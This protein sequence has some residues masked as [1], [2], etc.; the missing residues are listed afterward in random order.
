VTSQ[1][2][3]MIRSPSLT[4]LSLLVLLVFYVVFGGSGAQAQISF[5]QISD[6][7]VF[8]DT[9]DVADNRWNDKAAFISFIEQINQQVDLKAQYNF[10]VITGDLG[11]ERLVTG[12][13]K[14]V[15]SNLRTGA[16]DFASMLVLSKVHR[17]LF[18]PGNNDLLNE[19]PKSIEYYHFFIEALS[20]ATKKSIPDFEIKDL[21]P[22]G[23]DGYQS[24]SD[25]FKIEKYAFVGF[26]DSSFKNFDEYGKQ[27]QKR[28][29]LN[30]GIQEKYVNQV[31]ARLD[32]SDVVYV[33]VFYHIPAID[34]PYLISQKPED[35]TLKERY[36]AK[37]Q[38]GGSYFHSAWFVNSKVRIAWNSIVIHPKIRGLFAGH[39]HDNQKQTYQSLMWL[40][41]D[42]LP[43][44]VQKLHICP[45]LS[46]KFQNGKS[47]QARGFQ[48]VYLDEGGNVST[49]IF[50]LS[51]TPWSLTTSLL[52]TDNSAIEQLEL[53]QTFERL[54]RLPEAEAAYAKAAESKWPPTR[55]RALESLSGLVNRQE[56]RWNK[57]LWNPWSALGNTLISISPIVMLA[58]LA[59]YPLKRVGTFWG[60]NKVKIGPVV[61]ASN[62]NAGLRFDQTGERVLK[63]IHAHFKPLGLIHNDFTLPMLVKSQ[64]PEIKEVLE[65]VAPEGIGKLLAWAYKLAFKPRY[66]I[67]GMVDSNIRRRWLFISLDDRHDRVGRWDAEASLNDFTAEE[68]LALQALLRLI[69]HMNQ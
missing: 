6:P 21:C 30:A 4:R 52:A 1:P 5:V 22:S 59:Y 47:E 26:D 36:A 38:I 56:S 25:V 45:P 11:L 7:H 37:T 48:E 15:E 69:S 34:D 19:E 63:T 50:W 44:E 17:W 42:Y 10:V 23:S 39:F 60:R 66:S 41:P 54:N 64:T 16:A 53:G 43:D 24:R 61:D 8:D 18:V 35:K 32:E 46:L 40:T 20:E 31:K 57:F 67:Q 68:T 27:G 51:Q 3:T 29:D 58:L 2:L 12:D 33:Y 65:S 14:Q 62:G 28:I 55:K 49:R 9:S 13:R